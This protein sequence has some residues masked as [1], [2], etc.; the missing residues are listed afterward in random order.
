[1]IALTK[2]SVDQVASATVTLD[3]PVLTVL[4]IA[5]LSTVLSMAPA[6]WE[7][8]S[9]KLGTK[10]MDVN[11]KCVQTCALGKGSV[12]GRD[13][14]ALLGGLVLTVANAR[15]PTTAEV[16]ESA[17]LVCVT[18]T[19]DGKAMHVRCKHVPTTA[20]AM[21]NASTGHAAVLKGT[22]EQ[23]VQCLNAPMSAPTMASV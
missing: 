19:M 9:V 23:T 11:L 3:F 20:V 4:Q 18:A 16:M 17:A 21:D 10:V 22:R 15:A 12:M 13:V 2:V 5:V 6:R 1:M 7:F 14:A 8:A